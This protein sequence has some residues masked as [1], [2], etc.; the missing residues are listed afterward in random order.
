MPFYGNESLVGELLLSGAR[1]P[2]GERFF[3]FG[4]ARG[5]GARGSRFVVLVGD[6]AGGASAGMLY[7]A[8]VTVPTNERSANGRRGRDKER[9]W[10]QD[11]DYAHGFLVWLNAPGYSVAFVDLDPSYDVGLFGARHK[12][13]RRGGRAVD[14]SR[15]LLCISS[16]SMP[17]MFAG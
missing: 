2:P 7:N 14:D 3:G 8:K 17:A 12:S 4:N 10:Q 1:I 15:T 16:C 6:E 11:T 13:V 5:E 9:K